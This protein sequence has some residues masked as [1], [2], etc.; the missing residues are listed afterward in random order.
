M[1]IRP[2][3]IFQELKNVI[4]HNFD[5]ATGIRVSGHI[6]WGGRFVRTL[7]LTRK[8]WLSLRL[9]FPTN[10]MKAFSSF[11]FIRN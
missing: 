11:V 8:Y 1:K 7:T 6:F 2:S 3:I 4:G 10:A 9:R 5:I